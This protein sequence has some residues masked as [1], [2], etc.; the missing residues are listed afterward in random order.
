MHQDSGDN[1]NTQSFT[2]L[3]AG[4]QIYRYRILEKIG[5]GGM[6]EVWLAQDTEL[7]RKVALKFLAA[8]LCQD[9]E[10][11]RRF[12]REAQAAAKLSHPNII[13]IHEVGEYQNRPFFAMEYV[14]GQS[15]GDLIKEKKLELSQVADLTLQICEG[16]QRAHQEEIIHRD[17]KPSNILIDNEGRVKILDFGLA[18]VK[19]AEKLTQTGS[20]LGTVGYMSPEQIEVKEIDHR[21]DLF[22]LGIVL[23]EMITGRLPFKGE[24]DAATLN[25]ILNDSPEPLSRYKSDVP[26]ELQSIISKLLQKFQDL[27]YQHADDLKVDLKRIGIKSE[28]SEK[29]RKPS[30][31]VLPFANLSTDPEQEYFCDGMAEEIINA[32]TR[33]EN[34]RVIARTSAFSFKG[35]AVDVREIGR[36][37]DVE[38]L[39]EGSVRKSGN[40]LRIMAQLITTKDGSHIWSQRYDKDMDD[41]F[42]VQDEISLAIVENLKLK[43]VRNEKTNLAKNRAYN[44]EAYN[45]YLQG[46]YY[47]NK[48]TTES[49]KKA[50]DCF[51]QAIKIDSDFALAYTGLADCYSMLQ[52]SGELRPDEAFPMAK[53]Y[54][55]KALEIDESLAEAHTSLAYAIDSYDWDW[56]VAEKEYKRALELNPGYATGHQWYAMFLRVMDRPIPAVE[57]IKKAED[58]DPLSLIIKV[59]S[60][61]VYL[62]AGMLDVAE[63]QCRK[64]LE[65]DPNFFFVHNALSEIYLR[66]GNKDRAVEERLKGY[67]QHDYSTNDISVLKAAYSENGWEGFW[68]KLL[69]IETKSSKRRFIS[70][71][72]IALIHAR[73]GETNKVF[74]W[75]EKGYLERDPGMPFLLTEF[76]F[77]YLRSDHRFHDL[78]KKMNLID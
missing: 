9:E 12:K 76:E 48:R 72:D 13:T 18:M 68:R 21:S 47:W 27:R 64:V 69:Q 38:T 78:L 20:T 1:N 73:L 14:E 40:R 49:L 55:M 11:R 37:L 29:E 44:I 33:I 60:A 35:K 6:G 57:E 43:L 56:A 2:V 3:S 24:T 51:E 42:A 71:Y 32:L 41:V 66:K 4:M 62:E 46:R 53:E 15:L 50:T 59:A 7:D 5:S 58:L 31:A 10:C 25:S 23:Y 52:Q 67:G 8:H 75:L 36:K 77:S 34:L 74:D 45:L 39:L 63:K 65:M 70:S 16:L 54:A 30:I 28:Y 22:S 17:I 26:D 61:W 19:G